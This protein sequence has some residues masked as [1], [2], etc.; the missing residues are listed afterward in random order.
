MLCLT[1]LCKFGL[2][3]FGIGTD[4]DEVDVMLMIARE[5]LSLL[6]RSA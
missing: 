5:A 1:L 3:E 6:S 4:D 2:C